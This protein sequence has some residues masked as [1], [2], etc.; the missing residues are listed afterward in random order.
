MPLSTD[1]PPSRRNVSSAQYGIPHARES[2]TLRP[3][4]P[5]TTPNVHLVAVHRPLSAPFSRRLSKVPPEYSESLS[6]S[7]PLAIPSFS[8]PPEGTS[9]ESHEPT[10]TTSPA[11]TS[12]SGRI[13]LVSDREDPS[14]G[15]SPTSDVSLWKSDVR[16]IRRPLV[17][18]F[19]AAASGSTQNEIAAQSPFLRLQ[20]SVTTCNPSEE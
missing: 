4:R 10:G 2:H 15:R 9:A 19:F 16:N 7:S 18:I 1:S 17:I 11:G 13:L 8:Q 12:F 6:F 5:L 20:H 14:A 3:R